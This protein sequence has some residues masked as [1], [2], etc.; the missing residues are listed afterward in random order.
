MAIKSQSINKS[1]SLKSTAG[2]TMLL[3]VAGW[4]AFILF[5]LLGWGV[6]VALCG[7]LGFPVVFLLGWLTGEFITRANTLDALSRAQNAP[8]RPKYD[9]K[10]I[11][12]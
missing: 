8:R 5:M 3:A 6:P 1:Q 12:Q 7:L 10:D 11:L 2:C 4:M 9:I